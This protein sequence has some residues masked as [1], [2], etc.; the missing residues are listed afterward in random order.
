MHP[1]LRESEPRRACNSEG[2]SCRNGKD[3]GDGEGAERRNHSVRGGARAAE[4]LMDEAE[5]R[6]GKRHKQDA[7]EGKENHLGGHRAS[8]V[9]AR[10]A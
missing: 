6:G 8:F 1:R 3:S 5:A 9:R 2:E 7:A 4:A 10:C